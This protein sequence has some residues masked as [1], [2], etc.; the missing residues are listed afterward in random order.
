M[1]ENRYGS[2]LLFVCGNNNKQ[3]LITMTTNSLL[4]HPYLQVA[5]SIIVVTIGLF[6]DIVMVSVQLL[7][8]AIIFT[9]EC[10]RKHGPWAI[11]KIIANA[12]NIDCLH[13]Y[14]RMLIPLDGIYR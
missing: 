7:E 6:V 10:N 3:S 8:N 12:H 9:V 11:F 4:A 1:Y 13:Q 2:R 5:K 14:A